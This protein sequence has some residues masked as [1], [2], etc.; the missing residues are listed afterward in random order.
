MGKMEVTD[1]LRKM[2]RDF[3][4][5]LGDDILR[6]ITELLTNSD[7]SYRR[8]TRDG[9]NNTCDNKIFIF[10]EKEKRN[11]SFDDDSYMITVID[12]AEG[13][14]E[15]KLLNIFSVYGNDNA[16]G[17]E[18]HARGIFGQGASDVLRAAAKERRT[19]SIISIKDNRVSK[20]LY[21]VDEKYHSSIET[22]DITGDLN[23]LKNLREKYNIPNNG[24]VV[25]F[26][27]PSDVKFSPKIRKNM[28]NNIE[29]YPYLRYLLNQSDR[30]VFYSCD[31]EKE[32]Q[33]SSAKYSFAEENK[34]CE[35][36]FS[37]MFEGK[38]IDCILKL[39]SNENK[40]DDNTQILVIDE[41]NSVFDNTMFGFQNDI[42]ARNISGELLISKLYSLCYNHL[43]SEK[44][45][46]IV[47]DNRTGFDEKSEFYKILDKTI[48]P[49]LQSHLDSLGKN[50]ETTNLINNKKFNEALRNLNQYLK[51]EMKDKI[52]EGGNLKGKI[53]P[54]EGIRFARSSASITQ[55]KEYSL[56]LFINP[57]MIDY[58]KKIRITCDDSNII[59]ISP[60]EIEYTPEEIKDDI[61][62]KS[63]SL[64]GNMCTNEPVKIT[65]STEEYSANIMIDVIETDIHYPENGME[66]YPSNKNLVVDM[67]H[68]LKL[69]VDTSIIPLRSR[70]EIISDGLQIE[71]KII[72]FDEKN[73]LNNQIAVVDIVVSGG[74]LGVTYNLTAKYAD[75]LS[76]AV[77]TIVEP[78]KN[79]NPGGGYVAGFRIE[80]REDMEFQA[81]FHPKT[82]FIIINSKNPVNILVLGEMK[83]LNPDSPK[84]KPEQTKY[85]CDLI[86]TQAARL[87]VKENNIRKGEVNYDNA[88]EVVDKV[89]DLIQMQKNK[90][91]KKLYSALS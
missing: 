49:I 34:L 82:H 31:G 22:K 21:N 2:R 35:D 53:P 81:Y 57:K 69:Y 77:I 78:S 55:G 24:T 80:E 88:E 43:N 76:T 30:K 91:F 58:N 16:G 29:K 3:K 7:D 66:F 10:L 67:T 1:A 85:I 46:A 13:M 64:K 86:S 4:S 18:K 68:S 65:A 45:E 28:F 47:R 38:K 44:A 70:I 79:N 15:E 59:A 23:S 11:K 71:N 20:L 75:L 50:S 36:S 83:D 61:V 26:G 63:I 8:M 14:S 27:I 74:N 54:P 52:T 25:S 72:I 32:K 84:F 62:T 42:K 60:S 39:Y 9:L 17:I 33:L 48:S 40:M 19:A 6:F 73:L 90:I 89:Q 41:N 56:K 37:F 87:L 5:A 51:A 12:N